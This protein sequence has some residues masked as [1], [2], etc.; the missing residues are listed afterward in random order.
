MARPG[1][2][3]IG[4]VGQQTAAPCGFILQGT[5]PLLC[6]LYLRRPAQL[7]LRVNHHSQGESV[8]RAVFVMRL[9]ISDGWITRR[10]VMKRNSGFPA[11]EWLAYLMLGLFMF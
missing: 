7:S 9:N 10:A 4:M 1:S 2:P 11:Y 6:V 5:A 3:V 8:P